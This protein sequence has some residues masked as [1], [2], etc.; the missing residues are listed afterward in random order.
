MLRDQKRHRSRGRGARQSHH[1]SQLGKGRPSAAVG[2]SRPAAA[3][4]GAGAV[5]AGAYPG[6]LPGLAN[7]VGS[8]EE[9]VV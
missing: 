4:L 2:L 5:Q 8:G 6:D 3:L 7:H 9:V 1:G